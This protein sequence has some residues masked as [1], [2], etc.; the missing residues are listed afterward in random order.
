[1]KENKEPKFKPIIQG[2]ESLSLG[3]SM[4]VAVLIG[5]GIG[6]GLKSLF[7]ATWLLWVGVFIGIGAAFLNVF[8]A[9]SKQYKEFEK[10]SKD[11]RY[12][13]QKPLKF[14]DDDD[15]DIASKHY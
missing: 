12:S 2:A 1:M 8:K 13:S 5:I 4:V 10:L 3:I 7:D 6:L 15:D 11:P 9:Y 14:D